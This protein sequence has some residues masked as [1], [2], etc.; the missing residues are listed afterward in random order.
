M[1][2]LNNGKLIVTLDDIKRY[3]EDILTILNIGSINVQSVSGNV[4]YVVPTTETWYAAFLSARQ[5][6]YTDGTAAIRGDAGNGLQIQAAIDSC[7]AKRGDKV[8]VFGSYTLTNPLL[9]NKEGMTLCGMNPNNTT[10]G[11][12]TSI[13]LAQG[14]GAGGTGVG[15]LAAL[16]I[17]KSKITIENLRITATHVDYPWGIQSL[18]NVNSQLCI[19]NVYVLVNGGNTGTALKFTTAASGSMF[20]NLRLYGGASSKMNQGILFNAGSAKCHFKNIYI[21]NTEGQGIYNAGSVDDIYENIVIE[22]TCATGTEIT[23]ATSCIINSRNFATA[24][25]VSTAKQANVLVDGEN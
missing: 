24:E 1:K 18:T 8:V 13:T 15:A 21:G 25:G 6:T 10:T 14:S 4:Y 12:Q 11:G 23:G 2:S 7:V 3:K 17:S 19:R 22:S 9:L 20:E 5:E 16:N